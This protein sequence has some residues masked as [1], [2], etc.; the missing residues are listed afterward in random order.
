MK[1]LLA[2]SKEHEAKAMNAFCPNCEKDTEQKFVD[3]VEEISIRGEMIPIHMEYYHC[4]ECGEDFEIPRPDYDP[5]DAAYREYRNRNTR[6]IHGRCD[7]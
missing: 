4:E 5:L 6:R 1:E 7:R 2:M 3:K